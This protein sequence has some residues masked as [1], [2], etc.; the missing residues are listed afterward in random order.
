MKNVTFWP[1]N[2]NCYKTQSLASCL[3]A[4]LFSPMVGCYMHDCILCYTLILRRVLL[5]WRG[6]WNNT[7]W[8]FC[9][10]R[11]NHNAICLQNLLALVCP[12]TKVGRSP[13]LAASPEQTWCPSVWE[14]FILRPGQWMFALYTQQTW[15]RGFS[16]F[17][18]F[19]RIF[20]K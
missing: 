20:S 1:Y 17:G 14:V 18:V 5:L 13:S 6:H 15:A 2:L 11:L 12:E 16:C 8:V 9:F 19:C 4:C 3:L 10:D 7:A